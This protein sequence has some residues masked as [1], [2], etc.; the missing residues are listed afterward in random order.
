[1]KPILVSGQLEITLEL[2]IVDRIKKFS[3]PP[4]ET[5]PLITSPFTRTRGAAF[6]IEL[7][8]R[9]FDRATR[10]RLGFEKGL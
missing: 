4:Y 8:D 6:H 10:V 2:R 7:V 5:P 9:T 1:M 3:G